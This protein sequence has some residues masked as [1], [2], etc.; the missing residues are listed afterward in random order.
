MAQVRVLD[1]LDYGLLGDRMS[2][3]TGAWTARAVRA[4][5]EA[6]R[7]FDRKG[8][9]VLSS[10]I[11]MSMMLALFPFLLFVVA[12]AGSLSQD[13]NVDD[14]VDLVLGTW[15]DE[16]AEPIKAEMHAVLTGASSQLMT[17]GGLLAVYFASNGVDAVRVAM[18]RAYRD[19]DNL[20]FWKA[21]LLC[22]VF[23][24]IGGVLALTAL[25]LGLALPFYLSLVAE[26]TP[27]LV[28]AWL[29]SDRL[30]W[31]FTMGAPF[32]V[33]TACHVWLPG[34]R[35]SLTQMVPGIL[36]TMVMW[37]GATWGFSYYLTRFAS[38]SAIY[39]GLAG[40]MAALIFMYLMAAILILGA[41]FNG[42]LAG[43]TAP[44]TD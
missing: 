11:A 8:G 44:D 34:H 6:I 21:R 31:I 1:L 5:P 41:E 35:H 3:E 25:T 28:E 17:L 37:I 14:L 42:A 43:A 15:P 16:I 9:W 19:Q 7:R 22:V 10:H 4:L 24:L 26:A 39:A 18:T 2:G 33:V 36:L 13:V 38:Y 27:D 12:L 40:T 29:T 23:V 20:A 30:S 32:L